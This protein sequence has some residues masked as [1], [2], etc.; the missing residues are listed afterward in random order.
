VSTTAPPPE[1][2]IADVVRLTGVSAHTLRYY[3][4]AGLIASVDR[5]DCG[6]RRYRE[7]HLR[8]IEVLQKLRATG[9]PIRDM[10]RYAELVWAGEGN[11]A[12]RLELLMAHRDRVRSELADVARNLK[13]IE[14]KCALY[15]QRSHS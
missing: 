2:S 8:W 15:A 12:E 3:E 13:F 14:Q 1:L 9:M 10:R 5:A 6:H 4:R 11:E 7:Q